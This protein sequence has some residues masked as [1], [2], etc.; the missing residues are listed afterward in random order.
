M[1]CFCTFDEQCNYWQFCAAL[2]YAEFVEQTAGKSHVN[3]MYVYEY[4]LIN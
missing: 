4:M 3:E 2:T 1:Y